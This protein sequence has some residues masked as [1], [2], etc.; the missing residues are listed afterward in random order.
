MY[1]NFLQNL[2]ITLNNPLTLSSLAR[3]SSV[4][5][6]QNSTTYDKMFT[7]SRARQFIL[8]CASSIQSPNALSSSLRHNLKLSFLLCLIVQVAIPLQFS[9]LCL[10]S[11]TS[12]Y[13]W[14]H[15]QRFQLLLFGDDNVGLSRIEH[16]LWSSSLRNYL[17]RPTIAISHKTNYS[18][19]YSILI[20]GKKFETDHEGA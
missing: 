12:V 13:G 9:Q 17:Y 10:L 4:M 15:F 1:R 11:F 3:W 19:H 5:W 14:L 20:N 2:F 7:F 8:S 18:R 16:K 6:S